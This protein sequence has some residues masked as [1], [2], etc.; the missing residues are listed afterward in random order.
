MAMIDIPSGQQHD[1]SNSFEKGIVQEKSGLH[2]EDALRP[3][4]SGLNPAGITHEDDPLVCFITT[5]FK[6]LY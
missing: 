3:R 2:V 6:I 4:D 5:A 1:E